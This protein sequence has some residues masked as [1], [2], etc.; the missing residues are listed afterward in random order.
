VNACRIGLAVALLC[1]AVQ[2][3]AQEISTVV[4]AP[5]GTELATDVYLP[6]GEGPWP[7][8]LVRTPYDKEELWQVGQAF[9]ILGFASAIQDT[10]GRY[11]SG[12]ENTVFRDDAEDGRATVAWVTDQWWCDGNIGT[13]GGSAFGIPQYLLAPSADP[14]LK[15]IAPFVATPDIYHHA[16]LQGGA[17]REALAE[18]WLADQDALHVLEEIRQ[19]RLKDE[20]WD[21]AE[22]L[23]RAEEIDAAG[24]HVGGWYDIFGQGAIDAFTTL[25]G[26]GGPN[27]RQ[28]QYLLMGPWTHGRFGD[29]RAGELLYPVNALLD[30]LSALGPWY[31]ATLRGDWEEI[32]DWDPV[33]VYLMGAVGEAGAPGN[34][35]VGL[36]TWPPA[37]VSRPLYLSD[38]GSLGD[39]LPAAGG[40]ELIVDPVEPVPTLGGANL[41]PE[42]EVD[43][44]PMG[45]GPHDLRPIE[46]RDDVAVFSTGVL[47]EGLTVM[48]RLRCTLWVRPDT[49]D[50]DLA[51]RLSDVY[52]DGRSM[53]VTDGIQRSRMRCGD[54]RECLLTPGTPTEITVDLWSSAI[55]FNAGHRIR[56]SV[57]GT[58]SPRFE[59]NPNNGGD[60]NG[61]DPATVARPEL[62]FGP[63]HPSRLLLPIPI[64][65]RRGGQRLPPA[66]PGSAHPAELEAALRAGVS[67]AWMRSSFEPAS[68]QP[69]RTD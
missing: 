6:F 65:P 42:L 33:R 10:R 7:V 30:V 26:R 69:T 36:E 44:R 68:T 5:D 1:A 35:W 17:V 37:S 34:R 29:R 49:T 2:L 20:W 3:P 11:A 31:H 40:T 4:I 38:D 25:Q 47:T 45:D 24:L 52:P 27:A 12:G 23:D 13:F 16:F 41:F 62:L 66:E 46:A 63:D 51:V 59:V 28:R 67:S 48:G 57:S 43:G 61:D 54:D 18:N 9:K 19:H 56:I 21:P 53:L 60:L 50:L 15:S 64:E 58:N 22:V 32:G 8:I 55:V 14:A 39:Q